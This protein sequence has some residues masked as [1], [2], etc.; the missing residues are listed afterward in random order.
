M[1]DG[2]RRCFGGLIYRKTGNG[3]ENVLWV[4][5]PFVVWRRRSHGG[6][7]AQSERYQSAKV[8]G[9]RGELLPRAAE[10]RRGEMIVQ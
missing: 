6:R 1:C 9:W 3:T 10:K 4:L 2:R 5:G 7:R 8:S